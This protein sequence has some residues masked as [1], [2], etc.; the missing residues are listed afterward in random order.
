M[1]NTAR[2]PSC[3]GSRCVRNNNQGFPM[4]T[5]VASP[6]QVRW[7]MGGRDWFRLLVRKPPRFLLTLF[8]IYPQRHCNHDE[9]LRLGVVSDLFTKSFSTSKCTAN[10]HMS[11]KSSWKNTIRKKKKAEDFKRWMRNSCC[12]R[13]CKKSVISLPHKEYSQRKPDRS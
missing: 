12:G 6:T 3:L 5:K 1:R 2:P 9:N 10:S 11:V 4:G 7:G 8:V 13:G